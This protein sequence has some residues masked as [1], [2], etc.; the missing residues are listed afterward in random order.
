MEALG[1][2]AKAFPQTHILYRSYNIQKKIFPPSIIFYI[3]K[4]QI[5][6]VHILRVLREERNWK[7]IL[8]QEQTY[9]YPD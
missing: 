7:K 4:E 1:N 2:M 8:K 6:E 5:Q 3:F 9:T